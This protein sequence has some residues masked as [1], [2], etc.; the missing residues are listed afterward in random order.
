MDEPLASLDDARKAEIMPYIERLRDETK[1]P[2][3]YVSHSVAEVA[4]L[5]TDIVVLA[6]RQGRGV[7]PDG[8]D[9]AA[10]RPSARGGAR[11]RRRAARHAGRRPHDEAFGMSVLRSAA[12]EI[13]VAGLEAP[14]GATV[15]VRIRARDVIVATERPR[16]ISALNILPGRIAGISPGD[17]ALADV[18]IDCSGADRRRAHH[19]AVVACARPDARPRCVRGDQ[20]RSL[21]TAPTPT[22]A[23]ICR[24]ASAILPSIGAQS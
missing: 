13:R 5:A 1:I 23:A 17:G 2:I 4:R 24:A 16:G 12:G 14:L 7:R 19:P 9:P 11:R 6:E 15:R 20:D 21:S 22:R 3:V 8:R 18:L 10:A